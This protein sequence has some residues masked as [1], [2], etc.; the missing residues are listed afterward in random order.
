MSQSKEEYGRADSIDIMSRFYGSGIVNRVANPF[1]SYLHIERQTEIERQIDIE[2]E[3][4]RDR[5]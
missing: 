1:K 5:D 4:Y 2:T 3:R